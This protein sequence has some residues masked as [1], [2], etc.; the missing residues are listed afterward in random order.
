MEVDLS[1]ASISPRTRAVLTRL[2][3]LEPRRRPRSAGEALRALRGPTPKSV[4]TT[5]LFA[6]LVVLVVW[7]LAASAMALVAAAPARPL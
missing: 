4:A 6:A 3:D 5:L 2:V 7:T 1:S